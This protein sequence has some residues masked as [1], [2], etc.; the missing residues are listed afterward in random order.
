M[1]RLLVSISLLSLPILA[2]ASTA[3]PPP[4][5][6]AT[7]LVEAYNGR[8]FGNP[9]WRRVQL[10]LK[11]GQTVTRTLTVA[12]IWREEGGVVRTLFVLERPQGLKGTNYLLTEAPHD[13][14][15][16]K[17]FLHLPAGRRRVLSIQPSRLDEGL[18]GSDF[19]YR[20]L[21]MKIPIAGYRLRLLGRRHLA[22]QS[23]WAVESVPESPEAQQGSSWS[24][25]VYYL[26]A[27]DPV[28]LGAD[29]FLSLRDTRP[30]KQMRVHG[31]KRIDG[32]WTETRI[33]M[34]SADG[35]SSVLS[36]EGFRAGV[37]GL[38]SSFFVPEDLPSAADRLASL[39]LGAG[40]KGKSP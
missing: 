29:H 24:R 18:L 39:R 35:R 20:D 27:R 3:G 34:S 30:A 8:S 36:L 2:W 4:A 40:S 26:S 9:G 25:S 1:R 14:W 13:P 7:E 16:M 31:Y 12:N 10:E 21:R 32:A 23:V 33:V 5:S 37:A 38:D 22:G 17:V 19:G 11:S 28:L 15:G 6:R